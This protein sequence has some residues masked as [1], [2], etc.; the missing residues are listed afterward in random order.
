MQK[1]LLKCIYKKIKN[2]LVEWYSTPQVKLLDCISKRRL[3]L[4]AYGVNE[5]YTQILHIQYHKSKC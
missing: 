5:M 4:Y 3:S 1:M 2:E